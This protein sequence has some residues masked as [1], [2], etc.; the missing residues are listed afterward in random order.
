MACR[1]MPQGEAGGE[2]S[3]ATAMALNFRVLEAQE[4]ELGG[5]TVVTALQRAVRSAQVV[6][7]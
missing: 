4:M 7:G 5:W 1:H 2:M 3:V 6:T